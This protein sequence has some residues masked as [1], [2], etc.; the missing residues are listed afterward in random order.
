[1]KYKFALITLVILMALA[2]GAFAFVNADPI[3]KATLK[4]QV[5]VEVDQ[6]NGLISA[7]NGMDIKEGDIIRTSDGNA[8]V[9]LY[10][11]LFI[12]VE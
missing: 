4:A 9:I 12:I 1:M 10:E 6:G 11:S 8:Q 3:D 5:Q 7:Q 2:V